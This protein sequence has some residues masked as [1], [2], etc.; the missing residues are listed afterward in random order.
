MS[1][2]AGLVAQGITPASDLKSAIEDQRLQNLLVSRI[3]ALAQQ[4]IV[5]GSNVAENQPSGN[6]MMLLAGTHRAFTLSKNGTLLQ[7][8]PG[9]KT[10]AT[11]SFRAVASVSGG[12]FAAP[13]KIAS[14][15]VVV[16]S[17]C[18]FSLSNAAAV[19]VCEI[20][21]KAVFL[22]CTFTGAN[23][24]QVVDNP[25]A[26]GNIRWVGCFNLTGASDGN[27]TVVG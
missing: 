6:G 27:V 2:V 14:S 11:A 13:V 10:G 26:T 22:G 1:G 18:Q 16:F 23:L 9:A 25:G 24:S 4:V 5:A 15:G 7:L 21:A 19:V 8:Q 3:N 12:E 17:N 20:G